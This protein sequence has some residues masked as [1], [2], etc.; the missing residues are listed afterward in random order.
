MERPEQAARA[1]L[2][3]GLLGYSAVLAGSVAVVWYILSAGVQGIGYVTLLVFGG[4][5]ILL[6]YQVLQYILDL[7]APL[8]ETEGIVLK[9]WKRADLII[10]LDS[11]YLTVGRAIFRIRPEDWV[12]IDEGMVVKIVH[13]QHTLN[14]VSVH[15]LRPPPREPDP[16]I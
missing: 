4:L 11:F 15:E 8:A 6:A 7:R 2:I 14:V 10:F 9:K 3:R 16:L 12:L 13:L 5:A 1:S